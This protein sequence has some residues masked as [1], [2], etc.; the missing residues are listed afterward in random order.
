MGIKGLQSFLQ[1]SCPAAFTTVNLQEMAKAYMAANP[2]QTPTIVV[3]AMCCLRYW[4]T[5]EAWVHGGQWKEFLLSL[6]TFI[7]AFGAA[8]IKL[9]FIFDGV[10]EQ[11]KRDEWVR[12]RLTNNMEIAQI[13]EHIKSCG[14]QPGRNMF[15]IPSGISTFAQFA[16]KSLDQEVMCSKQEGDYEVAAYGLKNKCLGILGEDSDYFIFNTVPY[17]SVNQLRLDQLV[18]CMFSREKL[19]SFL[20]FHIEDLPLFACLLGNDVMPERKLGTFHH[21]CSTMCQTNSYG[22]SKRASTIAAVAEFISHV[23]QSRQSWKVLDEILPRDL[24]RRLLY[25]AMEAYI[26]P[27]Q[28]SPWLYPSVSQPQ[29]LSDGQETTVCVDQEI[30]QIAIEQHHRGENSMICNVLCNGE[31]ECSNT[32]ED[33]CDRELPGQAIIY[34]PVRQHIYAVLLGVGRGTPESCP[35]VKEWFVYPGNP[36]QHPEI[37]QA[38][39]LNLPGGT[40]GVRA[41]WLNEGPEVERL[42]LQTCLACFHAEDSMDALCAMQAPVAAVCCL[43]IYLFQKVD[44]LSLEDLDAF[45]A[46]TLCLVG[47]SAHHL[48]DLELPYVVSRAVHLSF[49]FVRGLCLMMGANSACGF[50]FS[51][52]DLMPWKVFDGKLFHQKYLQAHRGCSTEMLLEDNKSM[53]AQF[54]SLKSVI[55]GVCA[56]KS[57]TIQNNRRETGQVRHAGGT[58]HRFTDD[59]QMHSAPR[60]YNRP[61]HYQNRGH[62]WRG[63]HPGPSGSHLGHSGRGYR[64]GSRHQRSRGYQFAPRWPQ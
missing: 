14:Q 45:L 56:A 4:Y 55:S 57:R 16:L 48:K 2:G 42:R 37:V 47:K 9:V 53:H 58:D 15:F 1:N 64:S 38:V 32:L 62:Q 50:P 43:L 35:S 40:P 27:G 18:T 22:R 24:D 41:L 54:Q 51:M 8:G 11:K 19:C 13:F 49:L 39:P 10:V 6:S 29:E 34:R 61:Y 25:K 44:S 17:F 5:P 3:D 26:L 60:H 46:Q 12:R 31:I 33:E 28:S 36:L 63:P 7:E 52:D 23:P 21:K 59:Q 30:L 20:G